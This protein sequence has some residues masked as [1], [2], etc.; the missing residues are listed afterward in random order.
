MLKKLI[1]WA[2]WLVAIASLWAVYSAQRHSSRSCASPS[3][4]TTQYYWDS[5]L[6][7]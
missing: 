6:L 4:C 5:P 3:H 7:K 2:L 1:L